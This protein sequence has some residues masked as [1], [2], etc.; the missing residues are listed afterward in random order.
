MNIVER[1]RQFV[2]WLKELPKRSSWAWRRCPHCGSTETQRWGTYLRRVW[3]L[4]G[5]EEVRVP[6]HRCRECGRTYSETKP[7]LVRRSW[8]AREVQRCAVDLWLHGRMSLRRVAEVV[9]S[10]VGRQERFRLWKPWEEGEGEGE[11]CSL[12]AST[13]HRWLDGAGRR[14]QERVVG[15]WEGVETSEQ[16]G[17]DGMWV[18]L[19]RGVERVVLLL[20]DSVTGMIWPPVVVRGEKTAGPWERLFG[21]AREA[22][23]DLERLRG[24]TSDGATGVLDSLRRK[25]Y[26][27]N[28][29]RCV[30]HLWRNLAGELGRA[31]ARVAQE[32]QG[33]VRGELVD[34]VHQVLDAPTYEEAEKALERLR[35]HPLGAEVGRKIG[36]HLDQVFFHR[37]VYGRGLSRVAPEW[38]WRDFRL[39]LS[40]GRNHGSVERVERAVLVWAIYHNFTPRQWRS[41]RK[42]HYRYP[43]QS[44]L[45][46]ARASPGEASYLDALGV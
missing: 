25:L 33:K 11:R 17:V 1:A 40:R 15:Q 30:W 10:W 16:V 23:L 21:R 45:E 7:G 13:V 46:V 43:G 42:R 24:V 44:P 35:G 32:V 37:T 5:L 31:V 14:A 36:L 41:E 12:A 29:Q 38:C 28:H 9:R 8:Y 20:V 19:R 18:R 39:R 2:Q 6:R 22:G 34:L 27:V 3:T 26:W 4:Q